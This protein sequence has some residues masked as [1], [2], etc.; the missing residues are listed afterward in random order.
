MSIRSFSSL[1]FPVNFATKRFHLEE[2][3]V[4]G[5]LGFAACVDEDDD[6]C[7]CEREERVIGGLLLKSLC[8][9][10]IEIGRD[11][12]DI[13]KSAFCYDI[14]GLRRSSTIKNNVTKI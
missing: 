9:I 3:V 4:V 10:F 6:K 7:G 12:F 2:A 14:G 1:S 11:N 5:A 13:L 8:A